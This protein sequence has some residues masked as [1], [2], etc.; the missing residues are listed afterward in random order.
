MRSLALIACFTLAASE[1]CT[2]ELGKDPGTCSLPESL[3]EF[4]EMPGACRG[5]NVN[6]NLNSYYEVKAVQESECKQLCQQRANCTGVETS[7]GRCEL[8]TRKIEAVK[9]LSGFKCWRKNHCWLTP[10]V[11]KVVYVTEVPT[12]WVL[13]CPEHYEVSCESGD[14]YFDTTK[15]SQYPFHT[16]SDAAWLF[17][18]SVGA[19]GSCWTKLTEGV[20]GEYWNGYN[21]YLWMTCCHCKVMEAVATSRPPLTTSESIATS[22][23]GTNRLPDHLYF[24][25]QDGGLERACR[26]FNPTESSPVYYV[27]H[28]VFTL[29][30]CKNK[31]ILTAEC[32]GVEYSPGR[33]EVWTYPM[34]SSQS[35]LGYVCLSFVSTLPEGETC[36]QWTRVEGDG[37]VTNVDTHK[38]QSYT[39][40]TSRLPD[41]L[42]F[43]PQD[44]G[45]GRACRGAH[46]ND[47][48]LDYYVVH[49]VWNIDACKTK[50]ILTAECTGIEYSPGRCEVW[51]YPMESSKGLDGCACLSFVST[52]PERE[53]CFQWTRVEGDGSVTKVDTH[54]CQGSVV[55]PITTS[56]PLT[57]SESMTTSKS[58]T[59]SEAITTS[60]S[61][62]ST[63]IITT[64]DSVTSSEVITTSES[65]ATSSSG[66]SRLSDHLYFEPQDG[67]VARACS[68]SHP[69]D[70]SPGYY[71]VHQEFGLDACKTKCILTAECT[72]IEY[73]PGRCEVWT[74]PMQSSK[75][76]DGYAC[77][78][79]VSTVPE[80]ETCS[81]WTRV[82][83]DGTVMNTDTYKCQGYMAGRRL[84]I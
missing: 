70:D 45:I 42:Y 68:G 57:S 7:S 58:V 15:P 41:H 44:G 43:A 84:L 74:H 83:G 64:S 78:S 79:F 46:P 19:L 49:E 29:D 14:G 26:R 11:E 32:T 12:S 81:H 31:C 67:G 65:I 33:C 21:A 22:S 9:N 40:S 72:G 25:P 51:T 55:G 30:A 8:W 73:S 56:G 54:K 66:T 20:K 36:F 34:E 82:E 76:L 13:S 61:V 27:V 77:L 63:E 5:S 35:M 75:G 80:G 60:E 28:E 16:C 48:S 4:T 62:T 23:S 17:G 38:C 53:T 69:D 2:L 24:E 47:N 1:P 59:S 37:S 52:V 50:C 39:S 18:W 6:D 3:G 71:V 10:S